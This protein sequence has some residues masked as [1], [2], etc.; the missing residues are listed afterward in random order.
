MSN[1]EVLRMIHTFPKGTSCGRDGLRAQHLVDMLGGAALA[2]AH[3][4]LCSTT[5]VVILILSGKRPSELGG[6]IPSAP[7]TPLVKPGG[8]ICPIADGTVW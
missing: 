4:L 5:K 2:I 6:F 3:S 7:L 8:G 1:D